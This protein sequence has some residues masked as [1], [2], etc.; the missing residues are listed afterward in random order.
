MRRAI[1]LAAIPLL[2]AALAGCRNPFD[3]SA[4]VIIDHFEPRMQSL[5]QSDWNNQ[6][7]QPWGVQSVNIFVRNFGT[8]GVSFTSFTVVYRQVADQPLAVPPLPANSPIAAVGGAEGLT[9][10]IVVHL[11][12][13]QSAYNS[14]QERSWNIQVVTD[15]LLRYIGE[16]TETKSGGIDCEIT[17]H[18]TDHNGHDVTATGVFHIE[19]F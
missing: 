1:S 7:T 4:D 5:N 3:P 10:K 18:G 11:L 12:G 17:M 13:L 14:S 15:N 8:V 9:F 2:L 19:V 16:H 6:I